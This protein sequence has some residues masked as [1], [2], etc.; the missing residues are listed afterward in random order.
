M[1]VVIL[2]GGL[3][4]RLSEYTEYIPKPMIKI[5]PKPMLWHIMNKYAQFR[6]KNFYIALGY[7]GD[8]VK[9]YFLNYNS[10][11]SDFEINLKNGNLNFFEK[12][13]LDW[14]VNLIDT[15][16]L[17][18]TG[19]RIKRISKFIK[20]KKTFLLTYGD[21]I[22]NIDI[23]ELIK[24]HKNSGKLLTMTVVRPPARFGKIDI[25]S[26]KVVAFNEK[27]QTGEGW[28][29]G[30]FFVVEPE[31]FKYIKDDNTVFE[32]EPLEQLAK[33]NKL[34][35]YQHKGFWQCMDTKRDKDY[36]ENLWISSKPPW[37]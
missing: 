3:G 17:S 24:Y 32:K 37:T 18:M 21:G 16:E 5:G 30:G 7:K 15:G 28:I 13:K 27:P 29:N 9:D 22:A 31:I 2:A 4:S 8:V 10:L 12:N 23:D 11:N 20:P 35:A 36:L 6:H 19:G 26:N 14:K 33:E 34:A 25:Q 1:K